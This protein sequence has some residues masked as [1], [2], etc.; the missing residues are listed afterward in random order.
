M[1]GSHNSEEGLNNNKII[2]SS[3]K[4]IEKNGGLS[5]LNISSL[6]SLNIGEIDTIHYCDKRINF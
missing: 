2:D 4:I 1:G 5:L 6:S 3:L